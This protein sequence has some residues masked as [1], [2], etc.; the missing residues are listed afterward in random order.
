MSGET[1]PTLE[2]CLAALARA[3]LGPA[4]P[5][6]VIEALA[7]GEAVALD[8]LVDAALDTESYRLVA[9]EAIHQLAIVTRERDQARARLRDER[10][11][12]R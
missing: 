6:L 8:L 7:D 2:E 11:G 10:R 9:K 3:P 4:W 5:R 1:M 12:R